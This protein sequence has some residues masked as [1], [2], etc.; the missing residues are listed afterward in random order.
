VQV[1]NAERLKL[2][3]STAYVINTSRGGTVDQS[4]LADALKSGAIAGAAL[5]VFDPVRMH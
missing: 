3:K 4:A 1:V 5:D 2:M